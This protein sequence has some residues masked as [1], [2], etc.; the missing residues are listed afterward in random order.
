MALG[1][2]SEE[3][4]QPVFVAYDMANVLEQFIVMPVGDDEGHYNLV[5][6]STYRYLGCQ[7]GWDATLANSSDNLWLLVGFDED[8]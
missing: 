2:E 7:G 6:E 3:S 8:P 1:T 5:Q 4:T